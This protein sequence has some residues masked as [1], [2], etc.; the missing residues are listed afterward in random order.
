MKKKTFSGV[1]SRHPQNPNTHGILG[2]GTE[3]VPKK[4]F[5]GKSPKFCIGSKKKTSG[6]T[7]PDGEK[8]SEL[9]LI[10]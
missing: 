8:K 7:D 6:P 1:L 10:P 3:L 9:D 5:T 2:I 4:I